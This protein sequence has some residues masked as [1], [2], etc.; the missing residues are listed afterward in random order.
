MLKL[1]LKFLTNSLFKII[2]SH[3]N[4]SIESINLSSESWVLALKDLIKSNLL[5][6]KSNLTGDKELNGKK[7]IIPPLTANSPTSRT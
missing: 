2:S 6:K 4:K 5:P 1:L 3:G 7:S